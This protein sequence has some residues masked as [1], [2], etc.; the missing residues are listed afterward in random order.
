MI[1]NA[2]SFKSGIG[3]SC[4]RTVNNM[5]LKSTMTVNEVCTSQ[6]LGAS[7]NAAFVIDVETVDLGDLKADDLGS[8]HPT[9]TKK[10]YFRF[11]DSGTPE[12]SPWQYYVLTRRYYIHR[13]YGK[14][15]RQI[16]DI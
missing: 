2:N 8:W 12:M 10:S 6:L 4:W 7:E 14:F 9:G 1:Q 11:S 15:H 3:L 13:S 5:L 16:T